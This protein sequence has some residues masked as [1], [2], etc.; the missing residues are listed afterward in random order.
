MLSIHGQAMIVCLFLLPNVLDL[1]ICRVLVF[2]IH[3]QTAFIADI[4]CIWWLV[5]DSLVLN[6]SSNGEKTVLVIVDSVS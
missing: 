3:L 4:W 6:T 1:S 5:K 2:D